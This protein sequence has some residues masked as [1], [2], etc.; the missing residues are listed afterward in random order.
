MTALL[1]CVFQEG[2]SFHSFWSSVSSLL[3]NPF[4]LEF[5]VYSFLGPPSHIVEQCKFIAFISVTTVSCWFNWERFSVATFGRNC[6]NNMRRIESNMLYKFFEGFLITYNTTILALNRIY[7]QTWIWVVTTVFEKLTHYMLI[8]CPSSINFN[9]LGSH[10][11]L[12]PPHC[13]PL[14]VVMFQGEALHS[15][16]AC[17]VGRVLVPLCALWRL[18]EMFRTVVR[19]VRCWLEQR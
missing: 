15:A 8:H 19:H 11:C 1:Y 14:A 13:C 7:S 17:P 3:K 4:D 18:W 16:W 2:L 5:S 9:V 6:W 10:W 12:P